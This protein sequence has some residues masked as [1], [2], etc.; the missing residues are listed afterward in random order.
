MRVYWYE[1]TITDV[2]S[3]EAWLGPG[4]LE[5]LSRMRFPKRRADWLLGRWT[6]KNAVAIFLDLPRNPAGLRAV[7]ILP[8]VSGAPEAFLRAQPAA[9]SISLS[10]REGVAICALAAGQVFLGCDIEKIET[11]SDAFVFDYFSA[12]EQELAQKTPLADRPRILTL[13]WSSKES[14]LKALREGLRLDPRRVIVTFADTPTRKYAE[15]STGVQWDSLQHSLLHGDWSP[16]QARN[17]ANQIFYLWW[18]QAGQFVRTLL[19]SPPPDLPVYLTSK[20]RFANAQAG[21]NGL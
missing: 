21:E 7:E 10:H 3:G 4:E 2:P 14:A 9:V 13:L 18:N 15:G 20:N 6:A 11:H 8:A 19:A 16:L 12:E 5:Y 1:Q 17:G